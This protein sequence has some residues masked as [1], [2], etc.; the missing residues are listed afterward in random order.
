MEYVGK[1]LC[2][3]YSEIVKAGVMSGVALRQLDSRGQVNK[4]QR[5]CYGTP[6]LYEVDSLPLRY[7]NEVYRRFPDIKAQAM[8]RPDLEEIVP[9]QAA[10]EFYMKYKLPD[11]RHLPAKFQDEYSNNCAI[12]NM[13]KEQLERATSHRRKSGRSRINMTE[14]WEK[15]SM[16][17]PRFA[18]KWPHGLPEN[19]R[20]LQE[21]YRLYRRGGYETMI[22]GKFL[23]KNAAKVDDD[24]KGAVLMQLMSDPRNFDN[25]QIS[26]LY[27]MMAEAAGWKTISASA[28]AFHREREDLQIAARRL[29]A[30]NFRNKKSMQVKRKRPSAAMLYWTLDGW[31]AEL[32]YQERN[33]KGVVTYHNRL[34]IVVVLD[35][36]I[37]YPIGYAIGTHETPALIAEALRNAA[38]HT[39]ELFGQRYRACQIQSDRYA[40]KAMTP[41]YKV[42]GDIVIP[43]RAR[44]AK[45]KVVEP[46]FGYVNK[47]Y[48]QMM[49]NWSGVGVTARKESQPNSEFINR[50]KH[51]FPDQEGCYE[52]LQMI[53]EVERRDKVERYMQFWD[54]TGQEHRLPLSQQQFLLAFGSETGH[55]N[56]LDHSGLNI[57]I[58]GQK[59]TYDSFDHSFR[60]YSHIRWSIKYD[61]QDLSHVLAV[62]ED[63]SL[64]Y[65]LEQKYV[66]PMALVERQEGDT[67]ELQRVYTFNKQLESAA[68]QEYAR[69]DGCV[70][71]FL[72]ENPH[73]EL[74]SNVLAK[75]LITDS[76][77][78]HKDQRNAIRRSGASV[79]DVLKTEDYTPFTDVDDDDDDILNLL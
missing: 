17:L 65:L 13:F 56:A 45:S 33:A 42:M 59:L 54:A 52:Q 68:A 18:D 58:D 72:N 78:Q 38:N 79:K 50:F 64:Q 55:R 46:Y 24:I 12:L 26:R 29:G 8:A 73:L 15:K 4:V 49:P 69:L 43:A 32:Y 20:R 28:V 23:N 25:A 14:Y 40:I 22:S 35:P 70:T 62:N 67:A 5:A 1:K 44:N 6:A 53:M 74:K 16:S 31:D 48:C 11:G 57:T 30:T 9:D 36:C 37:N 10:I 41:F 63:N 51:S 3:S 71:E 61:T 77:G 27:N 39:A 2:I 19:P 47:K 21:K 60:R 76:N 7:K 34:T 75:H 66:Q